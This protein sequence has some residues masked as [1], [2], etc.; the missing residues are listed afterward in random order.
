MQCLGSRR[1]SLGFKFRIHKFGTQGVIVGQGL[2]FRIQGLRLRVQGLGLGFRAEGFANWF[3]A[4]GYG[5]RNQDVEFRVEDVVSR[6]QDVAFSKGLGFIEFGAWGV[7]HE[8]RVRV[9]GLGLRVQGLGSRVEDLEFR[10]K[11]LGFR[12]IRDARLFKIFSR[13]LDVHCLVLIRFLPEEFDRR[14]GDT[15]SGSGFR[16]QGFGFRVWGLRSRVQGLGFRVQ[17]LE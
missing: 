15:S 10:V 6:V 12:V 14:I 13:I 17:S 1:Q 9:L 8:F 16:V 3:G 5:R 2:G 4:Q 11:G 7:G